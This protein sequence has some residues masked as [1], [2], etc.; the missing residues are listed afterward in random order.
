MFFLH[1]GFVSDNDVLQGVVNSPSSA[2]FL[3]CTKVSNSEGVN[4]IVGFAIYYNPTSIISLLGSAQVV[5]LPVLS[6]S[7]VPA[8]EKLNL[9]HD[10]EVESSIKKVI[11]PKI[12]ELASIFIILFQ[13]ISE[14]FDLHIHQILKQIDALPV[15]KL[16]LKEEKSPQECYEVSHTNFT[17]N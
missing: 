2:D 17:R 4:P 12:W 13:M 3:L 15:L 16:S 8:I 10:E 7:Y 11:L 5:S 14:P 9:E 1:L 6:C